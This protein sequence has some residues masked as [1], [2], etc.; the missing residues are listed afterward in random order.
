L[1]RVLERARAKDRAERYA[2]A[3]EMREALMT[4]RERTRREPTDSWS[5][6]RK[7]RPRAQTRPRYPRE[8]HMLVPALVRALS[9]PDRGVRIGAA[10]ALYPT[11]HPPPPPPP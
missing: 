6:W 1:V 9:S 2:T 4:A 7:P 3:A 11:P 10:E 8:A 5:D